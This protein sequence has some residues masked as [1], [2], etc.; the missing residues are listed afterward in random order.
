M[1]L[2]E[3][4]GQI[5]V[6]LTLL[7]FVFLG[8]ALCVLEGMRSYMETSLAEDALKGAG[9]YVLSSYDKALYKD[10][11]VFFLDPRERDK[12]SSEGMRYLSAY[13][14]EKSYFNYSCQALT[15]TEEKT[16]VAEDG[17]YLKHQIREWMK[18]REIE[19]AGEKIKEILSSAKDV[20]K[21]AEGAMQDME[22]A[23]KAEAEVSGEAGAQP[24]PE[25]EKP[26]LPQAGVQWR[27]LKDALSQVIKGGVLYYAVD[28]VNSIS[29]LAI[30]KEDLPS[31]GSSSGK[32]SVLDKA[33]S[34]SR[35]KEWKSLLSEWKGIPAVGDMA[36]NYYMAEY[37]SDY[38][39]R[40]DFKIKGKSALAYEAEYLIGGKET[41]KENLRTVANRVFALRFAANYGFLCQ[42]EEW[43]ASSHTMA[44]ALTGMLGLPQAEKA[45]QVLLTSA[46]SFGESLL[47]VHA[48][49]AGQRIPVLKT[50]DSW[51][52]TLENAGPLLK[53]KGPVK[54]GKG[55][56]G[57]E[58]Y[59]RLLLLCEG[60]SDKLLFRMMDIMQV[61]T[62][63]EEPGFR[64]EDCL[65]SFRW[66]ADFLCGRWF[67]F[68]P[69][70]RVSGEKS[71]SVQMDKVNSY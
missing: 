21:K 62:A 10:Y 34:F 14:G 66:E 9:S 46:V 19:K 31:G 18:Y 33:L 16:A 32:K 48:L 3:E 60:S 39:R 70:T 36:D 24:P 2:R 45:V 8:L 17:L 7:F 51:N 56:T 38:F 58:E 69:G 49:F 59:I 25:E 57:Y 42:D 15:V 1:M 4:N 28:D 26:E 40:Y 23:E 27:S 54:G 30:P 61:N 11:H 68:F 71:F 6:Y 44:G 35:V 63:L 13:P 20:G 55:E 29:D 52:L 50:K 37:I 41:D 64:M 47:D 5:T 22:E 12:I 53:N 65:F 43:R 67:T